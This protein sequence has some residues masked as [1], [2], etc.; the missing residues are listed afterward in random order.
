MGL[1][2]FKLWN[3]YKKDLINYIYKNNDVSQGYFYW[4]SRLTDILM[5][6]FDFDG[7]PSTLPKKEILYRLFT[8]GYCG[9]RKSVV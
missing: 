3:K 8:T 7:L 1:L 5:D 9:D 2:D 4:R 6:I